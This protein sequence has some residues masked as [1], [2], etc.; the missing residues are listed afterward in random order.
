[1]SIKKIAVLSD[2][3]GN[4]WALQAVLDDIKKRNIQSIFNLGDSLYGPLD[5]LGAFTLIRDSDMYCVLGNEDRVILENVKSNNETLR[6][7]LNNINDEILKWL[8]SLKKTMVI[9]DFF[10]CH[11]TPKRDDIYLI[12]KISQNKV[13]VKTNKELLYELI[14]INQK[15]IL[16]GHS[17]KSNIITLNSHQYL[18]NPGSVGL[19]A[20]TDDY[21]INHKIENKKPHCS[22]II[23]KKE[24]NCYSFEHVFLP[25]DWKSASIC[26]IKNNHMNWGKWLETGKV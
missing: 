5:P 25:Y 15:V 14:D 10:L 7:V 6:Y 24:K 23:I 1:M 2:I 12:E 19:P 18:I 8:N 3:H 17:H 11:G 13:S 21:P 4:S 16:C 26:A 9:D 20:Y 22:Y